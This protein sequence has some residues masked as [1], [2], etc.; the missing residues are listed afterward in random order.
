L[1][2]SEK[3]LA[4]CFKHFIVFLQKGI[5]HGRLWAKTKS[6]NIF[7]HNCMFTLYL[8]GLHFL[9]DQYNQVELSGRN[10]L[11]LT[12]TPSLFSK[13]AAE[14]SNSN[15]RKRKLDEMSVKCKEILVRNTDKLIGHV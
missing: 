15:S 10:S 11:K 7:A 4:L 14:S 8:C 6:V 5:L 2:K 1:E 13:D 9:T 3:N 12:G